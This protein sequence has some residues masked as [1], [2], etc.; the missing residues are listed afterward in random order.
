MKKLSKKNIL[1]LALCFLA[2]GAAALAV[3]FWGRNEIRSTFAYEY[4]YTKP[5]GSGTEADPYLIK[6]ESEFYYITQ[7][8]DKFYRLEADL[9]FE[10]YVPI[11]TTDYTADVLG[12]EE[13]NP[14]YAFKGTFD[15]G[16][17]RI[18]YTV[19]DEFYNRKNPGYIG[20]F[21]EI[22]GDAVIKDLVVEAHIGDE[23][24]YQKGTYVGG[25][26]GL[27]HGYS[28]GGSAGSSCQPGKPGDYYHARISNVTITEESFI[29][30]SLYVGGIIGVKRGGV[31]ENCKTYGTVYGNSGVGGITGFSRTL[32][33]AS[34]AG[35]NSLIKD[36]ENYALVQGNLMVGGIVG[37][38]YGEGE[39]TYI[40]NTF[41]RGTSQFVVESTSG[42]S[43]NYEYW[44]DVYGY[45]AKDLTDTRI[46]MQDSGSKT[47]LNIKGNFSKIEGFQASEGVTFD[48]TYGTGETTVTATA[49]FVGTLGTSATKYFGCVSNYS[50][51]YFRITRDDGKYVYVSV[52]DR[53]TASFRHT[54]DVDLDKLTGYDP[55]ELSDPNSVE[56]SGNQITIK[57]ASALEHFAWVSNGYIYDEA[58][59]DEPAG[60]DN[61]Y[62]TGIPKNIIHLVGGNYDLTQSVGVWGEVA[63][64]ENGLVSN[65]GKGHPNFYGIGATTFAPFIGGLEGHGAELKVY[66]NC[67][68]GS[69]IGVL[70][71]VSSNAGGIS[72]DASTT[73]LYDVTVR[74][75]IR[76][77]NKVGVVGFHDNYAPETLY[78]NDRESTVEIKN[79]E[80]YADVSGAFYVGGIL[81]ASNSSSSKNTPKE[82]RV[83]LTNCHNYG[84]V[85]GTYR[86][87]GVVGALATNMATAADMDNV[88]NHG[89]VSAVDFNDGRAYNLQ[90]AESV[91]G[92]VGSVRDHINING[93]VENYG[94]VT[95][96]GTGRYAGG[97]VGY[98]EYGFIMGENGSLLNEGHVSGFNYTGG[99]IG[100]AAKYH[101]SCVYLPSGTVNRNDV[102]GNQ[103]VGGLM[104]A[105][106][107]GDA[108]VK[109]SGNYSNEAEVRGTYAVG[110][111]FGSVQATSTTAGTIDLGGTMTNTGKVVMEGVSETIA[112]S[113]AGGI[114]G[115]LYGRKNIT[116][117]GEL[118]NRGEIVASTLYAGATGD[119]IN[120]ATDLSA[121]GIFGYVLI[122][123]KE[124]TLDVS[125]D[126]VNEASVSGRGT[127]EAYRNIV[128]RVGG[129]AGY[130]N[131]TAP[132][133]VNFSGK[134]ESAGDVTGD[135]Y[136][137]GLFG[138]VSGALNVAGNASNA[139]GTSVNAVYYAGGFAGYLSGVSLTLENGF[140]NHMAVNVS[141]QGYA[142]GLFGGLTYSTVEEGID[143][144]V[145]ALGNFENRG[146]ISA[147]NA[148]NEYTTG[149]NSRVGGVA[150]N[151]SSSAYGVKVTGNVT[152][153]K[154][155]TSAGERIGG[156]FGNVEV[157]KSKKVDTVTEYEQK[158]L[159]LEGK[160]ENSGKLSGT[161]AYANSNTMGG[162]VGIVSGSL[163]VTEG[164]AVLN[165]GDIFTTGTSTF[166]GIVGS[167]SYSNTDCSVIFDG[168]VTNL[169]NIYTENAS[170]VGG[171]IGTL[172]GNSATTIK[173]VFLG[174]KGKLLNEGNILGQGTLGG[175]FGNVSRINAG[176][177]E[178]DF[179]GGAEN[180][181]EIIGKAGTVGGLGGKVELA[182]N[183]GSLE[184]IGSLTLA[185][186]W[187]NTGAVSGAGGNVGGN[188]GYVTW[189]ANGAKVP[190]EGG[191]LTFSGNFTNTGSVTNPSSYTGGNVGNV[192]VVCRVADQ[193]KTSVSGNIS[194]TGEVKSGS[195]AGGIF[196]YFYSGTASS[197][198]EVSGIIENS[199]LVTNFKGT[200]V[201]GGIFGRLGGSATVKMNLT[202]TE[203]GRI[204]NAAKVV[205]QQYTGGIAG[206][207][208]GDF[209]V[210]G[211]LENRG[212]TSGTQDVGG[213]FGYMEGSFGADSKGETANRG[214]VRGTSG[215][216]IGI[217]IG[218]TAA[219]AV[220][221][222]EGY[223]KFA[224]YVTLGLGAKVSGISVTVGETVYTTDESGIF[225]DGSGNAL[226][227]ALGGY[228]INKYTSAGAENFAKTLA[229]TYEKTEAT[230]T[231]GGF[232]ALS[233]PLTQSV[234]IVKGVDVVGSVLNVAGVTKDPWKFTVTTVYY[235]GTAAEDSVSVPLDLSD[236]EILP[237]KYLYPVKTSVE[238]AD[239]NSVNID[240]VLQYVPAE[241]VAYLDA[242]KAL[243]AVGGV[244]GVV[245]TATANF[246]SRY[247]KAVAALTAFESIPEAE[248]PEERAFLEE[249]LANSLE[250]ANNVNLAAGKAELYAWTDATLDLKYGEEDGK[251]EK[252]YK[253]GFVI[254]QSPQVAHYGNTTAGAYETV[255]GVYTLTNSGTGRLVSAG[256]APEGTE[257][258]YYR[259]AMPMTFWYSAYEEKISAAQFSRAF[260]LYS[261]STMVFTIP[262][263]QILTT[264]GLELFAA[265]VNEIAVE[266]EELDLKLGLNTSHQTF[267][268]MP[269][270]GGTYSVYVGAARGNFKYSVK[271]SG[272]PTTQ[273]V[274]NWLALFQISVDDGKTWLDG[275]SNYSDSKFS[276]PFTW[277]AIGK[278]AVRFRLL[279]DGN[280]LVNY[281]VTL[282]GVPLTEGNGYETEVTL[283]VTAASV[284]LKWSP[285]GGEPNGTSNFLYTGSALGFAAVFDSTAYSY[286]LK[287][288]ITDQTGKTVDGNTA[289][290]AGTYVIRAYAVE[291]D[292]TPVPESVLTLTNNVFTMTIGRHALTAENA[293]IDPIPAQK[294]TGEKLEP[295]TVILWNGMTLEQGRDYTLSYENNTE[296]GT[297][298]VLIQFIGNYEGSAETS[299][300]ISSDYRV[301]FDSAGGSTV[302]PVL[303]AA[304]EAAQKPEDPVREGYNFAGW[305]REG[306]ATAYDFAAPVNEDFR[307]TAHWT[308]VSYTIVYETGAGEAEG[309]PS[310]YTIESDFELKAPALEGHT[311]VGWYDQSGEPV[312][313]IA[314]GRTGNLVLTAEYAKNKYTVTLTG[315]AP[316]YFNGVFYEKPIS[317]AYGTAVTLTF[318]NPEGGAVMGVR[319]ETALE[320]V[321]DMSFR[322]T[323]GTQNVALELAVAV[324][325]E[326]EDAVYS[327]ERILPKMKITEGG[328][329]LQEGEDYT[330]E[331]GENIHAGEGTVTVLFAGEYACTVTKTF[332]IAPRDIGAEAVVESI[333]YRIYNGEQHRPELG[334]LWQGTA[335]ALGRDFEYVYGRNLDAGEGTVTVN[336]IGDFAGSVTRTFRIARTAAI[337]ANASAIDDQIL[338]EEPI[339]PNFE[340][341]M[342]D[343]LLSPG[344][345]F[346]V[347]YFDNESAGLARAVVTFKKN[348]IGTL[349]VTFRIVEPEVEEPE[350][351][352]PPAPEPEPEQPELPE[353]TS[354]LPAYLIPERRSY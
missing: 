93:A 74:G 127:N 284:A 332:T 121:G 10:N 327:G 262:T 220:L 112:S 170:T 278:Y 22:Y 321:G 161:S 163:R 62:A 28:K 30:G 159:T 120:T 106:A 150:G 47:T 245:T 16:N 236:T 142:G 24:T 208:Y 187:T 345:D 277:T 281:E 295:G 57:T 25:L 296:A 274:D 232:T 84:E 271:D 246:V 135:Y 259:V 225:R 165:S 319:T 240:L 333:L 100:Y 349:V 26:V 291:K 189:N 111:L 23:Y 201:T 89:N 69:F 77:K 117:S 294:Y 124:M 223:A 110:G 12:T 190:A 55:G 192:Y 101:E 130:I 82:S 303:A 257:S 31:V 314:P 50:G 94:D 41:N 131:L 248:T 183:N 103:Y 137:G 164:S 73:T 211:L 29:K 304:G 33:V 222:E 1:M 286:R 180:R 273:T 185:G 104:G 176:S 234:K 38:S 63:A 218:R 53:T 348:Y 75:V 43:N 65:R 251:N 215:T 302:L 221:P 305:F 213:I 256:A 157:S 9:T 11:C 86:V 199:G 231:A 160:F 173:T 269:A 241:V 224:A 228:E 182:N 210:N 324:V 316:A 158:F 200:S 334:V 242:Y 27:A 282:N 78:N 354:A 307:L 156:L 18:T 352:Q 268:T 266:K 328:K 191:K 6:T 177:V 145:L 68:E 322:F 204:E 198:L 116:V 99:I 205:G 309:N 272:K 214:T 261:G 79:V 58:I 70:G 254:L 202:V 299:F 46:A 13:K 226:A 318:G 2:F 148:Y 98:T 115:Y 306:A 329:T 178:I 174:G 229:Y 175:I 59:G 95:L 20:L 60:T 118:I 207:M 310:S 92:I 275:T 113:N 315:E 83:L 149:F 270:A 293:A 343:V 126:L 283:D 227:L 249:Y 44:G 297:A 301:T 238:V 172:L 331:Y 136:V 123:T 337:G 122:N 338:G 289:I 193:I 108:G 155:I 325:E 313:R 320:R 152:N 188:I 67:P 4:S 49:K 109:I 66:L 3:T 280:R 129:I 45:Q 235:D 195:Y 5:A 219:T 252:G 317:F 197:S 217:F 154:D 255:L 61:D 166:G 125:A 37:N 85:S 230:F 151:I 140:V 196:G 34:N 326:P 265:R 260:S 212:E 203:T 285:V 347:A 179:A 263:S 133:K 97:L 279:Q 267:V 233:Y 342:G 351:E 239:G 146:E 91:G 139:E 323:I 105:V 42:A 64:G 76:G 250:T 90:M 17:H 134:L 287:Y 15:G 80:N 144:I 353:E 340:V 138:S 346:T 114:V 243:N 51:A 194:N 32:G 88:T 290:D 71:A 206:Q 247:E 312:E 300:V 168:N 40:E 169:G 341:R 39:S 153:T 8:L 162:I 72:A 48:K 209:T 216:N 298:K 330:L 344:T 81:G 244:S 14:T 171:I 311:F 184:E 141:G 96:S 132:G 339:E 143:D 350:P 102:S 54:I 52:L 119:V 308:P 292:G 264:A 181:G 336:F 147:P 335:L 87:G 167:V 107:V 19:S 7:E 21:G 128:Q 36:C 186:T 35:E 56:K 253:T 288:S 258:G 237:G 276:A